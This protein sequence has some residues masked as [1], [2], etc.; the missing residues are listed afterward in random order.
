MKPEPRPKPRG[1]PLALALAWSAAALVA[2]AGEPS[3]PARPGVRLH[4]VSWPEAEAVLTSDRVVVIPLG[5]G[6]KEHGPHLPLGTDEI[7]ADAYA[8]ALLAARPVALLPTLSYGYYSK[9]LE[10]PG[11]TTLSL[12]TLRDAVVEI[13]RSIALHGPRRFYVL[14]TG[15]RTTDAL[16][17]AAAALA[18]EGVLMRFTDLKTAGHDAIAA[19]ERQAYGSHADEIE[20]SVMLYLA[21]ELVHMER[22]VA[23]GAHPNDGP[24]TRDPKNAAGHY[25]PS[26][27]FGDPTLATREKGEKIF[28]AVAA[29][30]V[31][32]VDAL[33]RAPLP[34][35][36]PRS[37]LEP[38]E[39]R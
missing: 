1:V 17:P 15:V 8:Q 33:S 20:T 38:T 34:G 26:G 5:A 27:V 24:L 12:E 30:M 9:M 3:P 18:K 35:G 39:K 36:R 2:T 13:C 4:D 25:S 22:A 11:T 32:D 10:Y 21:P 14:N 28:A 19:L 7:Q 31:A 23:D 16:A 37:P 6:S 29:A